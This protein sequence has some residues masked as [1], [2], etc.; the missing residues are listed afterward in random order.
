M[1]FGAAMISEG[2]SIIRRRKEVGI[3]HSLVK[4]DNM[5]S[6]KAFTKAGFRP[7]KREIRSGF[8]IVHM[9]LE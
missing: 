6:L 8:N 3:I 4:S 7:L 2:V 9:I 5:A 1:G